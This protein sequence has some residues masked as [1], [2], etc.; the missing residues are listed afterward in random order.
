MLL[1]T[2]ITLTLLYQHCDS[3]KKALERLN[4]CQI[5]G[6]FCGDPHWQQDEDNGESLWDEGQK[7]NVFVRRI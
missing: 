4:Q 1:I 7:L 2:F 3:R 5:Y 6:I